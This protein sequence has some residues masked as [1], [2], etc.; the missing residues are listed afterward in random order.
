MLEI[1]I[2]CDNQAVKVLVKVCTGPIY[3]QGLV[4][5]CPMVGTV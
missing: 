3:S 1:S 2:I 4:K 5:V